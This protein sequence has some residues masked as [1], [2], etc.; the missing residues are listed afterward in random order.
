M[1]ANTRNRPVLEKEQ[2]TPQPEKRTS[3]LD[4]RMFDVISVG[5]TAVAGVLG[6][7]YAAQRN[8]NN[9]TLNNMGLKSKIESDRTKFQKN[10]TATTSGEELI[11]SIEQSNKTYSDA[12][13]ALLKNKGI[14]TLWKKWRLMDKYG[15]GETIIMASAATAAA[16]G[17]FMTIAS[18]RKVA[19]NQDDLEQRMSALENSHHR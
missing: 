4:S 9:R 16:I 3:I 11:A 6:A 13:D 14:D 15:K 19:N 17:A 18:F 7:W 1:Q 8:F 5:V 12:K 10:L 2:T